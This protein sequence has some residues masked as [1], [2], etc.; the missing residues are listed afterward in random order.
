[1]AVAE[2]KPITFEF[3]WTATVTTPGNITP[4]AFLA[5][6]TANTAHVTSFGPGNYIVESTSASLSR[7][8]GAV[9]AITNQFVAVAGQDG[10]RSIGFA[11][12]S[13]FILDMGTLTPARFGAFNAYDLTSAFSFAGPDIDGFFRSDP[14]IVGMD[15]SSATGFTFQA[16]TGAGGDIAYQFGWSAIVTVPTVTTGVAFLATFVADTDDIEAFAGGGLRI[17]NLSGVVTG[18]SLSIPLFDQTIS[19]VGT[20]MARSVGYGSDEDF[21]LDVGTINAAL[22]PAFQAYDLGSPF[23]LAGPGV[24][25]LFRFDPGIPGMDRDTARDFSFRAY[26]SVSEPGMLALFAGFSAFGLF[27]ARR[28]P[29]R[30]SRGRCHSK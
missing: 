29:T 6:F 9:S 21:I 8:G 24:D 13:D 4:V 1:M 14:G 3:G 17:R 26:I 12:E 5:T 18:G 28:T 19:L 11:T 27:V 20:G 25:G 22:L 15:A 10:Q 16:V 7:A 2:A 30:E 23:S